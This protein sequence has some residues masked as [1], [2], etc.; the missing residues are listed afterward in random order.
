MTDH[1]AAAFAPR[2]CPACGCGGRRTLFSVAAE[3]FCGANPTYRGD[4]DD[5]LGT[6]SGTTFPVVACRRCGFAFAG[7]LPPED[8]LERLYEEVIDPGRALSM[9]ESPGWVAH[10]LG[11]AAL[12]LEELERVFGADPGLRVLDFGCGHGSLVR[13][14]NG[15]RVG[16]LGFETSRRRQEHLRARCLP[17]VGDLGEARRR[18]PY[19]AIVLS[20]VLEHVPAPRETLS[21]CRDLLLPRGLLLVCVP[22]F[23]GRRL[24]AARDAIARGG[25]PER[26]VNPWEHLNYF[27]PASLRRLLRDGG[28]AVLAGSGAID[29]GLRPGLRG[30]RKWGNGAK[31][32]FRIARHLL[33]RG[34]GSTCLCAQTTER[35][36]ARIPNSP[37]D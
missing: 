15:S 23:D 16:C 14:L 25:S 24:M 11:L 20:D 5:I 31:S 33:G 9:S 3:R 19:H 13:A 29:V 17:A 27:S 30:L 36:G 18:G 35:G 1:D 7:L 22:N 12:L 28:F 8:F 34:P 21:H 26:E 2:A 6:P 37:A 4:Y 10:Q 32:V